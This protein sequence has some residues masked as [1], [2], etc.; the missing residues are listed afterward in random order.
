MWTILK[1]LLTD[2]NKL[3]YPSTEAQY[4]QSCHKL[5]IPI[6]VEDHHPSSW[7]G[8]AINSLKYHNATTDQE[9]MQSLPQLI[10]ELDIGGV[11]RQTTGGNFIHINIINR[12]TKQTIQLAKSEFNYYIKPFVIIMIMVMRHNGE[13]SYPTCLPLQVIHWIQLLHHLP[14]LLHLRV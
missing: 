3:L 5:I 9:M 8:I 1:L 10:H 4:A 13:I 14:V 12:K 2:Y 6:R 11:Q 7:L